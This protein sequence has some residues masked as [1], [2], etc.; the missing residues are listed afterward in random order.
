M[1]NALPV[2]RQD[3]H[4]Y[5]FQIWN[6]FTQEINTHKTEYHKALLSANLII[7]RQDFYQASRK[8]CILLLLLLFII[9]MSGP[10]CLIE[11]II[12]DGTA[13]E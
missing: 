5:E 4:A 9:I 13:Y 10:T 1:S 6:C 12:A 2:H 7:I 11:E 8:N 3:I